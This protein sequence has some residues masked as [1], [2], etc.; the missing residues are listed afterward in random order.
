M[1][2]AKTIKYAVDDEIGFY[3]DQLRGG[4]YGDDRTKVLR[5]LVRDQILLLRDERKILT[6]YVKTE[7]SK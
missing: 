4:L 1:A 6:R 2:D 5:M 3:L 7:G